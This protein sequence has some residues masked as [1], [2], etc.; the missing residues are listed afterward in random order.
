VR[1]KFSTGAFTHSIRAFYERM[2]VEKIGTVYRNYQL[3][4]RVL[5][6]GS[7]TEEIINYIFVNYDKIFLKYPV[8][9]LLLCNIIYKTFFIKKIT[10]P[11]DLQNH[12]RFKRIIETQIFAT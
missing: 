3:F 6:N 11:N 10:V 4:T 1:G 5:Q 7:R 2:T 8:T 9:F 12:G